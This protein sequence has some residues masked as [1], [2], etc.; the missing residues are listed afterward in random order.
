LRGVGAQA[1]ILMADHDAAGRSVPAMLPAGRAD[2]RQTLVLQPF[3]AV[4]GTVRRNG[5]PVEAG[6]V[7]RP[8]GAPDAS[9][10][11]GTGPDGAFRFDRVAPGSYMLYAALPRG[12]SLG[13]DGGSGR[14]IAVRAGET[15]T[16]DID[17][18]VGDLEVTVAVTS[19]GDVVQYAYAAIAAIGAPIAHLPRTVSEARALLIAAP[20]GTVKEGFIVKER[21]IRFQDVAA[22]SYIACAVPLPGDPSDPQILAAFRATVPALAITCR[23]VAIDAASAAKP[24]VIAVPGPGG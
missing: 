18:Q 2:A 11:L 8:Q 6:V 22:G 13:G 19:P 20:E 16:T 21:R 7:L 4:Q 5:Q 12:D 17:I 15:T 14:T 1:Q 9:F 23:S 24:I 10:D 3:G